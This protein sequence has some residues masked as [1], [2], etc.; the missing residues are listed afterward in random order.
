MSALYLSALIGLP[1]WG[2]LVDPAVNRLYG[3]AGVGF[4]VTPFDFSGLAVISIMFVA[5]PS[6][7][8]TS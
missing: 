1:L 6:P 3:I 2:N 7:G 8:E 5:R 4:L